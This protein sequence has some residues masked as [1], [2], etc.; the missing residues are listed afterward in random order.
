MS[1]YAVAHSN[2]DC[3]TRDTSSVIT[4]PNIEIIDNYQKSNGYYIF[5][6][7]SVDRDFSGKVVG[8]VHGYGALNPMIF[9]AWIEHLVLQGHVVIYPRYQK[10]LLFPSA[11]QFTQNSGEAIYDAFEALVSKGIE[12]DKVDFYLTGHSFGGVISANLTA[13]YKEY[14]LPKPKGVL[15]AE[16]GTGPFTGA[17]EDSYSGVAQDIPIV[18]VVGDRD[19]TVGD[20]FGRKL[21]GELQSELALL[22]HQKSLN[23]GQIQI[24]SSHYE[25]YAIGLWCNN[26]MDNVTSE[27]AQHVGKLDD[28]DHNGYWQW[29][30]ALM[31]NP[32]DKDGMVDQLFD[33]QKPLKLKTAIGELDTVLSLEYK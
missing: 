25:P 26:S 24:T 27:R 18:V 15:V 29:L 19:L 3:E 12:K 8:F 17:M 4:H 22:I 30:D 5:I 14:D 21:F 33:P 20:Y 23:V 2:G 6:P 7:K 9:G 28:L 13:R 31:L 16:G 32:S 11:A 1:F 10:N